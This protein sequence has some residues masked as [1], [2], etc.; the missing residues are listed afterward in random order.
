MPRL[1]SYFSAG[2]VS[3]FKPDWNINTGLLGNCESTILKD[4]DQGTH[5]GEGE[6][7]ERE[8]KEK[9]CAEE[10]EEKDKWGEQNV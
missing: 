1:I 5:T 4:R 10:K 2:E 6:R 7:R 8:E 3:Q 9:V